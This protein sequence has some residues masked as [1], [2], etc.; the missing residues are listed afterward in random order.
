MILLIIWYAATKSKYIVNLVIPG[1]CILELLFN[2]IVTFIIKRKHKSK[3]LGILI[4]NVVVSFVPMILILFKIIDFYYIAHA[5]L[6][7]SIINILIL[8]LFDF[9]DLKEELMMIFNY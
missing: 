5:A 3:Y 2:D 8:V 9:S 1:L 6:L 4:A 7:L